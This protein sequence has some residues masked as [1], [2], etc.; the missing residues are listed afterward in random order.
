MAFLFKFA[1]KLS[2]IIPISTVL[3]LML[4]SLKSGLKSSS[5]CHQDTKD[6]KVLLQ[7]W[8]KKLNWT[9]PL[10][11]SIQHIKLGKP[12]FSHQYRNYFKILLSSLFP[13][14][15]QVQPCWNN[16]IES[17]KQH[18]KFSIHC[19][20]PIPTTLLLSDI[21]LLSL[22][23]YFLCSTDGTTCTMQGWQ[24]SHETLGLH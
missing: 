1:P 13:S 5:C 10:I 4:C 24:P 20:V 17:R 6:L 9:S 22:P 15:D 7:I 8:G 23:W 16:C 3:N 2:V 14:L 11:Y 12:H 18:Y 21:T 19:V